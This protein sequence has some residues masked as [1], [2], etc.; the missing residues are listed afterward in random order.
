MNYT[1][2]DLGPFKLHMIKTDKFKTIAV[3]VVFRRPIEK[4]KITIRNI[5]SDLFMQSTKKYAT[6]RDLTIKAQDLYA[7]EVSTSNSRLGNYITTTF[8]LNSL[9]DKYT[10]VG[11]FRSAV[12]FLGEIIFNPDVNDEKF[13]KDKIDIVKSNCRSSLNSLKED[14]SNYSLI[15]MFE[16]FDNEA[17]C[18]FRLAGYLEDLD[19]I[20]EKSLY[21]YY[22]DMINHD[23]VDVF[24]LGD[25]KEDEIVKIFREVFK[26]RTLKKVRIPY[27]LEEKNVKKKREFNEKIDNSQSKLSIACRCNELSEYERNYV[28]TLYNVILGGGCDSKLF[29]EVREENSLCYTVYSVPNKLDNVL[30][31]Q[32]GID[33]DN[34]D[35]TVKL[36][37]KDMDD[38]CKGKFSDADISIAREYYLTALEEVL[39]STDRIIDNYLM[40]ELIGTD[41]IE[42][43]REM[44]SKVTKEEIIKMAKK[45]KLDTIFLLEGVK[46]ERD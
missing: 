26:L 27:I 9:N 29:K 44:I 34:Y 8:H 3:K 24:V 13:N 2:Q 23:L 21:E 20:N 46:D 11:N 33:K 6:K 32:A 5:L 1:K 37:E 42:K 19:S 7:A 4:D 30:I 10:E 17:P 22:Q 35:K 18:S 36:I 45:V 14:S 28:L 43:K 16:E 40:M 38:M 31:I 25:F 39:E 12:E 41:T 15:R